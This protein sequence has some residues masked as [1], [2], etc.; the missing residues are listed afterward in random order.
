MSEHATDRALSAARH[1]SR[2]V[3]FR[4][5]LGLFGLI[6]G[7]AVLL[8]GLAYEIFP[9]EVKDNRFAGPFP[10]FPGPVLQ[11]APAVDMQV[12]YAQ[13]MRQLNSA[14][15]QDRAAGTVHIPIAQA[16]RAV[17]AEGI[18]GWPAGSK[19]VSLGDR[20]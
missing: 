11:P 20:R 14:G 13:E 6:G 16:M 7:I 17:A 9:G 5:M 12:F 3:S 1:E 10:S 2:D 8:I 4:F 19:T 18:K 15:W